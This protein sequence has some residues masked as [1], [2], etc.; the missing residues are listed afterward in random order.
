MNVLMP[1]NAQVRIMYLMN[2]QDEMPL[3]CLICHQSIKKKRSA[4]EVLWVIHCNELLPKWGVT[5]KYRWRE[6]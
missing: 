3:M 5:V 4:V 2:S 6:V 1:Q